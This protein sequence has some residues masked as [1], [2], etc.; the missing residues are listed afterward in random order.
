M[1]MNNNGSYKTDNEIEQCEESVAPIFVLQTIRVGNKNLNLFFDS[2]CGYTVCKKGA[3]DWL[4]EHERAKNIVQGPLVLFG[5]GDQKSVCEYG[6]YQ[7]STA[8]YNG[9]NVNLAGVCLDKITNTFPSYPLKEVE[10]DIRQ[11]F[12]TS[13]GN[14]KIL[15]KLPRF[16]S[17]DCD[18][19]IGIHYNKYFPKRIF[20]LPN[21]LSIYE[22]QFVSPDGSR[23]IVG[24]PHRI[25]SEIHKNLGTHVNMSAY[26]AKMVYACQNSFNLRLDTSL[27]DIKETS[28]LFSNNEMMFD[29]AEFS[30]YENN[31]IELIDDSKKVNNEVYF[32]KRSPKCLE[33]FE[34]VESAGT[35]V[36]YRCV[37]CRGCPDCKNLW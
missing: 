33:N 21:G 6:K 13:G 27:L 12:I 35:E 37:K 11:S 31:I 28:F 1:E 9:K 26:F 32:V 10:N 3:V 25:F 4:I 2:G 29:D 24:G 34:I 18:L 22:S 15:P 36:S 30:S 16:V 19:M 7:V 5:V 17:G 14:P 23:G 8:L 20:S